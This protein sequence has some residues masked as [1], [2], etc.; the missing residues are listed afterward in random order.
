M[1]DDLSTQQLII[2]RRNGRQNAEQMYD[3][4]TG[5]LKIVY[6]SVNQFIGMYLFKSHDELEFVCTVVL[7][8]IGYT[9]FNYLSVF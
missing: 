5:Q 2:T 3:L 4:F 9:V 1:T 7:L 6:F 8:L